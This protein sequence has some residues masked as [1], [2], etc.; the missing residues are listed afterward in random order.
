VRRL[1]AKALLVLTAS[2]A[3]ACGSSSQ[4]TNASPSS[5]PATTPV[6]TAP[7]QA[8]CASEQTAGIV[9]N[10]GDRTS[11]AAAEKLRAHA[12]A[13]GFKGLVVQRRSCSDYAVVLLGLTSMGQAGAFEREAGGAGFAV[14]IE[15]RSHSVVGTVVAVFGHRRTQR[16]ALLLRQRAERVGFTGLQVEQDR[17]NDW[18][19]DLYG[20][21]TGAQRRAFRKEALRVGFHVTFE[22]G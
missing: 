18:Q 2:Q 5:M 8:P 16:G 17:C 6:T 4:Q 15:C 21:K 10:F 3:A 11:T 22:A 14:R 1:A 19:V 9:A 13:A 12:D 20:L 7:Q